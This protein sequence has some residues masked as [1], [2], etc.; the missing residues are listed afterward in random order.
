M[1]QGFGIGVT[2]PREMVTLLDRLERG[3]I[4]S[5]EASR[6]MID[7]LKRQQ[8]RDG[9]FRGVKAL[10][11]ATKPGALD[12]LRSDVGVLD[13]PRGRVAVAVTCEDLPE[14]DYSPDNPA[15]ILMSRLSLVLADG[16]AGLR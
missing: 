15:L 7:L 12:H 5:P 14:V 4:V 13:T 10:S 3:E 2:T 9:I 6:E 11:A 16:L 8:Y 1:N